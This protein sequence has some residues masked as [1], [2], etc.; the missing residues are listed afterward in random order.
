MSTPRTS[1]EMT[2]DDEWWD[3]VDAEGLPTGDI[4][5]RGAADWPSGRFHLIVAV[6]VQREDGAVL[7]TQRAANK[8]F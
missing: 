6:C 1:F 8:E 5:R 3:V 4:Y 7:L 2:S